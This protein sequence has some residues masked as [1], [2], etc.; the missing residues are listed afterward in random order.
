MAMIKYGT[1]SLV[2]PGIS[3]DKWV[4]KI[5][6]TA[7]SDGKCR[8]KTAKSVLAKYDPKKYMLS[9]CT[10]I[11]AV[12]TDL[13]DP[14]NEKS[15][16][17]I[18]PAFSK[19]V[20]NNGDA[21]SK[22]MLGAC[23]KTFVGANNYLEHVQIPEL[24]KGKVIDAVL[25]DIPIGKDKDGSDLSTY[26][27]D[28]LVATDRKHQDLVRKIEANE[29]NTLSMGCFLNGTEITLSDGTKRIIEELKPGDL[30]ITHRGN[31]QPILNIQKRWYEGTIRELKIKG[32]YKTTYVTLEHPYWAF[33]REQYCAC[34]C[35]EKIKTKLTGHKNNF[36]GNN[37]IFSKYKRGHFSRIINPNTQI[38]SL[39]N[40]KDLKEKN[41]VN[42]NL[43]LSWIKAG[44]LKIGDLVSYPIT[45]NVISSADA[46]IDKARLIGY[47]LAE[48]SFV[49]EVKID[50][51]E[52]DYAV[53]CRVCGSL[54]NRLAPH[55]KTHRMT[56]LEYKKLY[57]DA[58]IGA[59][60]NQQLIRSSR[61][62][63]CTNIG[64]EKSRKAVGVEFSLGEHEYDTVNAEIVELGKKVFP[65]CV[66][67]RYK[68]CV[69]IIGIEA[70]E[71]FNNYGGEYF[72]GKRLPAEVLYWPKNIQK[73]ILSTWALGDFCTTGSKDLFSQLHYMLTRNRIIHN[74]YRK[75]AELY[76]TDVRKKTA[77]GLEVIN[78]YS[79]IRSESYMIQ[80]NATGFEKLNNE[81]KYSFPYSTPRM[82]NSG[83]MG[84][85]WKNVQPGH[86][87][88]RPIK[89][90]EEKPYQG[91][92]YNFEV[93]GDNS[94]IANDV[95]V[96]NCVISY[97]ICSKCGNRAVDESQAC[98]HVKYEKNN[99]FYDNSGVQRKIAE[100]C[101]HWSEPESVRFVDA[102]W[103][104]TPAFVG[105]VRR[106]TVNVPSDIM[107]KLEKAHEIE[108]YK[109][110]EGDF[111][112][113]ANHLIAQDVPEGP[114]P[115]EE[116]EPEKS[117]EEAPAE[118][119]VE[120]A[121]IEEAPVEEPEDPIETFKKDTKREI[122]DQIKNEI[123]KELQE[124][125]PEPGL[126]TLDE[127]IIKP[128][129]VFKKV[130][131]AK[132]TWDRFIKQSAG[133]LNKRD[134]DKL[135]YGTYMILTNSDPTVLSQYGYKKRDFLAVLS[136]LD[137]K[138]TKPLPASVK[139]A[140]AKLGGTNSKGP[141]ELLS[142]IVSSIGR[143]ISRKEA[144]RSLVWLKFL[145]KFS[146]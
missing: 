97:S 65:T 29:L 67:L 1:A 39:E 69:K 80:I 14:K 74:T 130:W 72:N 22:K 34:G 99:T 139:K 56:I 83:N 85:S 112:K 47:Y 55:L 109:K 126:E 84:R 129:S 106:N 125:G 51:E 60:I 93:K 100:L 138:S 6:E 23:Y 37:F 19:F 102:S 52:N 50:G 10:I 57:P 121:P 92:V 13:A 44:D 68:K 116:A 61:K 134:F 132:S 8:M 12:D 26:Y 108:G 133:N 135:R 64:L 41:S 16:Y 28:I 48:G 70:A 66:V 94:Y 7:C 46:T 73:H 42:S 21:W 120:E 62:E 144:E 49:K 27:V 89:S 63:N 79:G 142:H 104:K 3:V 124:K 96:H 25:R 36:D 110:K 82:K 90:I 5:Y 31:I 58:P 2:E 32:D 143:K 18:K 123:L 53:R 118:E 128:A 54:F 145:D 86:W 75:E 30:V 137:S 136:F 45:D 40:Y 17:L 4:D 103:V 101:G 146:V 115:P 87:F 127:T 114:E 59:K 9:H 98:Q 111:L 131:G 141:V 20:N 113:A 33:K 122:L 38:Y 35:G 15:D 78:H 71:F 43:N 76:E 11:A 24:S 119:P 107:A 105:A 88:M 117:E 95:A 140:I 91:W 77:D 81:L